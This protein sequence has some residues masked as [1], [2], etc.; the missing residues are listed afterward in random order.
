MRSAFASS[1]RSSSRIGISR[2]LPRR[3]SRS[4]G[5]TWRSNELSD[6]PSAAAASGL[7]SASRGAR[8]CL[9]A[10]LIAASA[11]LRRPSA[12]RYAGGRR[13]RTSTISTR[14]GFFSTS[15]I[16]PTASRLI[17]SGETRNSRP[18]CLVPMPG[19]ARERDV[20]AARRR[21]SGR[22]GPRPPRCRR[23]PA[24]SSAELGVVLAPGEHP[25]DVADDLLVKALVDAAQVGELLGGQHQRHARPN[26]RAGRARRSGRRRAPRTRRPR[27]SPDGRG[28]VA[29]RSRR[30]P[31]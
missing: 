7:L 17:S 22:C 30:R 3:M 26:A 4:S 18:R 12:R 29:P 31:P 21:R 16:R 20:P 25:L 6:M 19:L 15:S 8:R 9:R 2:S 24:T 23:C 14:W 27:R 28:R 11:M 1:Q 10:R 5:W 13:S